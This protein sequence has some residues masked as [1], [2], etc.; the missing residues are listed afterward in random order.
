MISLSSVPTDLFF[1]NDQLFLEPEVGSASAAMRIAVPTANTATN[2]NGF[3]AA[4]PETGAGPETIPVINSDGALM[5]ASQSPAIKAK[6]GNLL[7]EGQAVTIKAADGS[8]G[9]IEINPDANGYAHFLFEGNKGNFLNAQAPNLTSGS[10]Y[11]GMVPNNATGYDLIKL[12]SGAPKMTTRFSVDATGNTYIGGGLNVAGSVATGGTTRLTSGGALTSINGYSQDSGNFTITQGSGNYASIVRNGT[13]LNDVLTL[14]LNETGQNTSS[15]STLT[16]N[17]TGGNMSSAALNVESGNAIFNGQVQLGNFT[18][19][20]AAIGPGSLVYNSGDGNVYYWDGGAWVQVATGTSSFSGSFADLTGGTNTTAAMIVGSGASLSTSGIG[21]IEATSINCTNCVTNSNLTNSSI[22]INSGGILTGGGTVSL[23]GTLSLSATEA[24]TL[25]TVV[26]RGPSTNDQVSLNGGITSTGDLTLSPVGDVNFYSAANNIDSAGNLTIAGTTTFNGIAYTWPGSAIAG[27]VLQVSGTGPYTLDWVDPTTGVASSIY[28]TQDLGALYPKNNT[29]DVLIGATAGTNATASAKFAFTG[30]NTGGTPTASISGTTSSLMMDGNGNIF[31]TNRQNLV[32]GNSASGY[33]STGNILLNPNGTGNVGIG[34]TGPGKQVVISGI[35]QLTSALTNSGAFGGTLLLRHD[36]NAAGGGGTLLFGAQTTETFFAAIKGLETNGNTNTQG[37]LA[38]STRNTQSDASLTERM[39]IMWNGNVGI[40]T[41]APTA[42]LDVNGNASVSGTLAFHAGTGTIQTTNQSPLVIGGLTTGN[43]TLNPSNAIA[44]GN[45]SPNTTDVTDLGTSS[46]EYRNIY[47]N[48]LITNNTG[49]TNVYNTNATTLNIG[50]AATTALNIGNGNTA[51]TAINIGSGTGGNTINIAGTG[52]TGNNILNIGNGGTGANTINIGDNASTTALNL[53][54]GTSPQTFTSSVAT[55]TTTAGSF[56]YRDG[57]ITS[58]DLIYANAGNPSTFV[59]NFV[60]LDNNGATKY[61]IDSAGN[62]SESG[63]LTLGNGSVIQPAYGPLTLSYKSGANTWGAG[64]TVNDTT[65]YVGI[66]TT[67]PGTLLHVLGGAAGIDIAKFE[68]T[69]GASAYIAIDAGS[70]DPQLRFNSSSS[71]RYTLGYHV[72]NAS[73]NISQSG[74]LGTTDVF[75]IKSGNIGIGTSGPNAKLDVSGT[76]TISGTLTVGNGTTN[77]IQSPFGPLTFNYKSGANAWTPGITLADNTGNVTLASDLTVS[78][79]DIVFGNGQSIDNETSNQ[80][81]INI[82]TAGTL[83]L[84]SGTSSTIANTAGT[85]TLDAVGG[86]TALA[87]GDVFQTSKAGDPTPANG[88]IYYN[89]STGKYNI[90][91]DIGGTPTIKEICNKTDQACGSGSGSAWSALTN[92]AGN[93]SLNMTASG[94]YTTTFGW[95]ATGALNPWT[96]NLTNNAGSATVQNGVTINNASNTGSPADT[97]TESLLLLQQLDTTVG[98]AIVVDNALKIDSAANSGITNGITITNSGGNIT[99]GINIAD[100]GSGTLATG[101][102]FSGTFTN[103]ISLSNGET[104]NNVTDGTVLITAPTTSLSADLAVAGNATVSGNLTIG[105]GSVIRPAYGALN[106]AYKSG[107]NSWTNDLTLNDNTGDIDLA[108]GSTLTGCTVFNS[109]GNLTCSGTIS[110]GTIV[111][112]SMPFSGITT[113]TNI[114]A[115][116]VVGSGASLT[117]LGGTPADATINANQLLGATWTAPLA[118]GTTFPAAGNFTSIGVTTQGTGAFTTLTTSSTASVSG[119]LTVGNGTTNTIESAFGPLTLAYKSGANSWTTGLS[120]TDTTGNVVIAQNLA[121]NGGDL[122]SSGALNITP[123]GALVV[124]ATGQNA[125]LQGAITNITSNGAGNDITLTSA[126]QIILNAGSTIELQDATNVTGNLTASGTASVSGVLTVGNG[127]TNTIRSP[128]GPLILQAKTGDNSWDN[129]IVLS[130]VT[131]KISIG[132]LAATR[133]VNIGGV[134]AD[135]AS[136]VNIATQG[137]SADTITIGN[138]HAATTL[139]LTGG[140]AWSVSTAGLGTFTNGALT[141]QGALKFYEGTGGGTNFVSL[142]APATLAG[143]T[144]YTLPNAYP[145]AATGYYLTSNTSGTMS[146]S[147]SIT[148]SSL[149]WNALAPPDASGFVLNMSTDT[150]EF[151]WDTGTGANNLFSMTTD[152]SSNGTGYL[153]NLTTGTSSTVKPFHVSAAGTEA[154]AVDASGNVGIGTTGPSA[155]LDVQGTA[156]VS[157]ILTVGNGTTNTIRSPFGPLNIQAKTGADTWVNSITLSDVTGNIDI[158]DLASTKTIH[159]GGVNNSGTDTISIATEGTAADVIAIGNANAATTLALTG[160][161]AW[162]VSTTGLGTLTNAALTNQGALKFYEGTG[163]GTN[164]ISLAAPATLAGDTPYTLP[165]AYPGAA[166]GYYLTSDTSGTMSWSN[167]ITASSLKWNALTAPD[168]TLAMT[169]PAADTTTF[170]LNQTTLTGF[171][172]TSSTLTSGILADIALTGSSAVATPA[173]SGSLLTLTSSTTGFTGATQTLASVYSS[174]ANSIA[175][176]VVQGISSSVVNTGTTNTN[177]GGYFNASGGV[178]NYALNLNAS[179]GTTNYAIRIG[180]GNVNSVAAIDWVGV[181]NTASMFRIT[182][183]TTAL[184]ALDSRN[185]VSG[186][187]ALTITPRAPTIAGAAGTTFSGTNL[188]NYILTDSTTTT[189]N[190]LNG[191]QLN[192]VAP[193][194]N[195]SGGAVTVT[196]ASTVYIAGAPSLGGSVTCTNCFALD[197]GG[198]AIGLNGSAGTTGQ[199]L[200]S[201]GAST[202]PTWT[203]QGALQVRWSSLQAPTGVL[204]LTMPAGAETTFTVASTTQTGFTW[205]TSTLTSGILAKYA[206]TGSSAVATPANSGSLLTLSSATTGFTAATQTLA[207]VYS[208]GANG[209]ASV[210]VQG[211]S[212][213]VV[214]TGTTNTNTGGYFNAS[215]GVTNYALNLNASGGTT[216]YAIRIGAGNVNSVAAIDWVLAAN[217]ASTFRFFDGT[218]ALL[219]LNSQNTTSGAKALTI[220]PPPQTITAASGTTYSGMSNAVYTLTL[221]GSTGTTALNGLQVYIAQP[222]VTDSS[223]HTT[224][225]AST[226]YIAGAPIATGS[227]TITNKLAIDI[228]A[229]AIGLNGNAGTTGQVLT[230]AGATTLPTWTDQGALQVKWSSLQAPTAALNLTMPAT[231]E[232]AFTVAST[233]QTGFTWTTSTLTSGILGKFALTGSSVVATPANSGSILTLTSSATGFTAA[234]QTLASVYSSGGNSTTGVTVQGLSS[235]VTNTGT[236]STN[237]AAY[238]SASGAST[239]YALIAANGNVGIGDTTPTALLTV[240]NGD[241]F[242]VD[243]SGNVVTAGYVAATGVGQFGGTTPAAYNRFG[244][245][246]ALATAAITGTSDLFVSGDEEIS[247]ALYFSGATKAIDNVISGTG[248]AAIT[249]TNSIA[250]SANL[251]GYGNWMVQNNNNNNQAAFIVDQLQ[252]RDIFTASASGSPKFVINNAG[253]VGIGTTNPLSILQVDQTRND[254]SG[255]VSLADLNLTVIPS[256]DSTAGFSALNSYITTGGTHTINSVMGISNTIANATSGTVADIRG[257]YSYNTTLQPVTDMYGLYTMNNVNGTTVGSAYGLFA[258]IQGTG[259]LTSSYGVRIQNQFGTT[260]YGLYIEDVVNSG[261]NGYGI[262]QAGSNDYNYFAGNV[263]IGIT[264]PTKTL[265]VSGDIRLTGKLYDTNVTAGI[266]LGDSTSTALAAYGASSIVGAL[267]ELKNSNV[268]ISHNDYADWALNY[269]VK[270]E[271]SN[272]NVD[273]TLNGLFFDT[274]ADATK[275]DSVNSTSSGA[276]QVQDPIGANSQ[277]RCSFP[278]RTYQWPNIQHRN[279]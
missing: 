58:G 87:T 112:T 24:D 80:I 184:L 231:D 75:V 86:V 17:R 51:Y 154:I 107:A 189:V 174:G 169:I 157:G 274:F 79:N 260:A 167:S 214:N 114:Q 83:L 196:K 93:L 54:S 3:E 49:T 100:T 160:G 244:T 203:D 201:A 95:T 136:T 251:L 177:T 133:T 253:Y 119:V 237:I 150:T 28:W 33:N 257:V 122:T 165:N 9:N 222:T 198:G 275:M 234:T 134:T 151:N 173:N 186:V 147:N 118:I 132:D 78:G 53:T 181:A 68:R 61:L 217:T 215:G 98:N 249:L 65:G 212:S 99:N 32:L 69:S 19:N 13:A 188:A 261:T 172:W 1:Q 6:E 219:A 36:Q 117:Y 103:E 27:R 276:I 140:T 129:S 233:T 44:G 270:A 73:F 104:I 88:M 148:A 221:T 264:A 223:S 220:T 62:A 266:N 149:K 156:T 164:F 40:G 63:T 67:A 121:V 116:M 187:N 81:N 48:N 235:S 130:D 141:N 163:G 273:S 252:A 22:T 42:L 47:S 21:T 245:G 197:I 90:V 76:A 106:L 204:N 247:G 272:L 70:G 139:A 191:L 11:Y 77:T 124:G 127:A 60:K 23:G 238:L 269:K 242:Q 202:L 216:N 250:N 208:S 50:G 267:N 89:S 85:L 228:G 190:A 241:K 38:F 46:L 45:V 143:D 71:D 155:K 8:G 72:S 200:T 142:A 43:I 224:T 145:G 105:N 168:G 97:N 29:V 182:D 199:V 226:L 255:T 25:A 265:D 262:Y 176:A 82:G 236:T 175:S 158:G 39:R 108:G 185:T 10:L 59:G 7:V 161:T 12:Q 259:S 239:N 52:A 183:G 254:A 16:L 135:G 195:Q 4:N 126:D 152:N 166:S 232:T 34:T 84:T 248:T 66:G 115:A 15:Y 92:P 171:T 91:E 55:G 20:P 35:G 120:L 30:V 207:A 31:T 18:A 278:S 229:G 225:T 213:S 209:T 211:L 159:I 162:S 246:T 125:T 178:T 113:G 179:G 194:I 102:N 37:D 240:G 243:S 64:L 123:G 192:V 109:S 56:V 180:A 230:S 170:T 111:A 210:I 256:S 263:G 227:E 218:T 146:W 279:K 2:L 41:S 110:G 96:F 5:L 205:T 128:F 57:A 268:E 144:P 206:L 26:T 153:L 14:T 101:I 193:T 131:G 138:N 271:G 137:T 258:T 74:T 94:Q 277:T